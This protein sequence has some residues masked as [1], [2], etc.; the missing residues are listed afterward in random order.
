MPDK[1]H[2]SLLATWWE[3]VFESIEGVSR[4]ILINTWGGG[5]GEII[6]ISNYLLTESE[7]FTGNLRP[8]PCRIDRA[9]GSLRNHDGD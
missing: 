9:I 1:R 5:G 7:V 2:F 4:L 6:I 3:G 8:R